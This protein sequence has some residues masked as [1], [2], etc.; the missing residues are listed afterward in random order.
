[1]R[2][3]RFPVM[4]V[5]RRIPM[6]G[7]MLCAPAHALCLQPHGLPASLSGDTIGLLREEIAFDG[8]AITDAMNM[9]AIVDCYG[10]GAIPNFIAAKL[11][12]CR[13][14]IRIMQ[15]FQNNPAERNPQ[16]T[17]FF[18]Q[19]KKRGLGQNPNRPQGLSK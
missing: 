14:A 9:G 15:I 4:A 10:C 13:K 1:M 6:P 19:R 11:P 8:I 12:F 3:I 5:H 7:E 17:L 16:N 2:H 18:S